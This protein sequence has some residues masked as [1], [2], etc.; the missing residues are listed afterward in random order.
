[1]K[2]IINRLYLFLSHF[3]TEI[4]TFLFFNFLYS[5]LFGFHANFY[6]ICVFFLIF[7]VG[8]KLALIFANYFS[9]LYFKFI[10]MR[11]YKMLD[12]V[13]NISNPNLK[14]QVFRLTMWMIS[15]IMVLRNSFDNSRIFGIIF[16]V[17]I[18]FLFYLGTFKIIS[19]P[20]LIYI[21]I[22]LSIHLFFLELYGQ[23]L[24]RR[25][26]NEPYSPLAQE[27]KQFQNFLRSKGVFCRW[28]AGRT[29]LLGAMSGQY[30][31]AVAT[32]A[33]GLII[34]GSNLYL[35]HKEQKL[36]E[37]IHKDK[38]RLEEQKHNDEVALKRQ[39]LESDAQFK[40]LDRKLKHEEE[41][42]KIKRKWF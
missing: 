3:F 25:L 11:V 12:R 31:V 16:L 41:L 29:I 13:E 6:N 33:S 18:N 34:T 15:L 40:I 5:L 30:S 4:S 2:L 28:Y 14:K 26:L 19:D 22:T 1:M 38:Q 9:A 36:N 24:G 10:H 37:Q 20:M 39:A 17:F 21:L 35:G 27:Y 23:S 32:F 7:I 42:N 8:N